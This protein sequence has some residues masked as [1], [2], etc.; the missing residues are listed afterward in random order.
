LLLHRE[1]PKLPS[2]V[3]VRIAAAHVGIGGE[4]ARLYSAGVEQGRLKE[5]PGR[6]GT[7]YIHDVIMAA[8]KALLAMPEPKEHLD[9]MTEAMIDVLLGGL[10]R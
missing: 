5:L 2:D 6:L 4:F 3:Q 8:A 1:V 10:S 7:T 9:A